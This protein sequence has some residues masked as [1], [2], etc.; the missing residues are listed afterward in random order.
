MEPVPS[1]VFKI[2]REFLG[3]TQD[4]VEAVS[5]IARKTIQRIERGDAVT[6]PYVQTIQRFYEDQGIEFVTPA[7]GSGW[8]V[9]N[10]N[11]VGPSSPLNR[12]ADIPPSKRKKRP[13]EPAGDKDG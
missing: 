6:L 11:L 13:P 12:L 4:E 5:G 3:L 2:A 8:G 1:T 10:K 9:V 7:S